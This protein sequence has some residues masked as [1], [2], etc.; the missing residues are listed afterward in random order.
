MSTPSK[1]LQTRLPEDKREL[2]ARLLKE[3]AEAPK[4]FP[5]SFAQ[6]RLWFLDRF[7]PGNPAYN[8]PTAFRLAV[9]LDAK[10]L[11][12]CV[13]EVVRRHEV[14][15]TTFSTQAGQPVQV[16]HPSM[17][18]A[19]LEV[20][21]RTLPAPQ[22][23][24]EVERMIGEEVRFCFDLARGPLLR[25]RLLRLGANDCVLLLT[26]HH[27]V[28]DAWSMQVL[29]RELSALYDAYR[30]GR[31]SPLAALPIQYK[32]FAVWQRHRLHGEMLEK[33]LHYWRE[34]L[35]GAP[36]LLV[37][38]T[39][40]PRPA[41]QRFVGKVHRFVLPEGLSRALKELSRDEGV[42]LFMTLL[43]A[44]KVLLCRYTG[45]CNIV[46]GSPIANRN[47]AEI[48]NLIGFFV[49][50][51]VLRTDL[52]GHPSFREVLR[53]VRATT[54][55]AYAHQDLPFE[56]FVEEL[57]PL[58]SLSHNPLFQVMFAFQSTPQPTRQEAASQDS[59]A[60]AAEPAIGEGS[61]EVGFSTAK[62]DL[63]LTMSETPRGLAGGFEYCTDLFDADTIESMEG[64]FR[65]L[66]ESLVA[67][68]Q[69][70]LEN[71]AM[72]TPTERHRLL[73]E[74][75]S[76]AVAY[77]QGALL[78]GLFEAQAKRT[79]HAVAVVADKQCLSFEALNRQANQLA[80][81]LRSLGVG[82]DVSV[83]I[84]LERGIPMVVAV[85][86]VLKAGGA[87]LPLAPDYPQHRLAFMLADAGAPVLLTERRG[88]ERFPDYGGRAVCL[89]AEWEIIA[90]CRAE[91]PAV[92]MSQDHLAYVIYTSGSTGH[93]KGVAVS[94]AALANHMLWMDATWPL[95]AGDAVL[96]KTPISFDASLWE[97]FAPLLSGARLVLARPEDHKDAAYLIDAIQT[98]HITVLQLV[99]SMLQVL[100]H[101]ADW[102]KC[103]SLRRV[104]CG[105][106]V[107]S[108]EL[109]NRFATQLGARLY[110]LYGPTEATIDATSWECEGNVTASTVP[111]GRPISNVQTY[112]LDTRLQ[113]VPVGVPGELYIGGG[114]LARGYLN[115]P[116]LTAEKFIPNP[117]SERPGARLYQTGDIAR[118]RADGAIEFLGRVDQQ[119]KIRGFRIEPAE[120]ET[121]LR[122]EPSVRDAVVMARED[123]PGD[124]RLVAYIVAAK[125][126]EPSSA[127]LRSFLK[128][129]LPE[130]MVP[131]MFCTLAALPRTPSGKIDRH[132]LPAPEGTRRASAAARVAPRNPVEQVLAE[133]WREV[134]GVD[135][136]GVH[137]DF[138]D[139]G[140]H[141]LLVTQVTARINE[142][143]QTE[144]SLRSLFENPTIAV[145]AATLLD[146]AKQR[147]IVEKTAQALL[148]V[149]QLADADVE[150]ML[151]ENI[152]MP[153]EQQAP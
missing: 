144:L 11:E 63:T 96:Q 128:D 28:S 143:L 121:V 83:G 18:I 42:T 145:L 52:S 70:R 106:E 104:Y 122:Q 113:P 148:M 71:L 50:T 76:T 32:D 131:G 60:Q 38:P 120:I 81:H 45:Q 65:T 105:G 89:D 97:I 61:P 100:L 130:H 99:P 103:T 48:E 67:D 107:L 7:Q 124:Q 3:K 111:I 116:R 80:H 9:A 137:D 22:Q 43:A 92:P 140:G 79:P 93:P 21:L 39:D 115:Q 5:L 46:V 16:I 17:R 53:R 10:L 68:P 87:Y 98:H 64:H 112:I 72:L 74:W 90:G 66:L 109:L 4:L 29:F 77:P 125:D 49:N 134:L 78:H 110:N 8:V 40:R 86:G 31:P 147:E 88:L 126:A 127:Q 34:K 20:D 19:L 56:K 51:V 54:L 75:N 1:P 36:A 101:M 2:L 150:T 84:C 129:S 139:L 6:E 35:A 24:A 138:F 141:S 149:A 132:G 12:Q 142:S 73:R 41:L 119:V 13:N 62:F 102:K 33:H 114:G 27:I 151:K 44:F 37:L 117:F 26:M 91:N 23:A 152:S 58:R 30:L 95:S 82:P 118:Y 94:H 69:Q 85:L 153:R 135:V 25:V 59:N 136:V 57:R 47:R 108:A 14:L 55:G 15:R 123:T 146:D 133:I